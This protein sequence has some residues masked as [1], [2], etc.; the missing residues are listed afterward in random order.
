MV[1]AGERTVRDHRC[2]PSTTRERMEGVRLGS[3][4]LIEDQGRVVGQP[5]SKDNVGP[6]T[7]RNDHVGRKLSHTGTAGPS[8]PE[9]GPRVA[10]PGALDEDRLAAGRFSA[11]LRACRGGSQE[12]VLQGGAGLLEAREGEQERL[13][14]PKHVPVARWR[15]FMRDA[16]AL[17]A[18]R[19]N[20]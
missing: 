1:D 2:R 4:V 6:G 7:V 8:R 9:Y 11:R 12:P 3:S 20:R 16:T 19:L 18:L 15:T 5:A 14:S 17:G 10:Q 13:D